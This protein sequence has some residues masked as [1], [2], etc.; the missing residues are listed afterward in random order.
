MPSICQAL[1]WK[2]HTLSF[3]LTKTRWFRFTQDNQKRW[4]QDSYL[5]WILLNLP[6]PAQP[7]LYQSLCSK[8]SVL[9]PQSLETASLPVSVFLS[10]LFSFSLTLFP[11]LFPPAP[12]LSGLVNISAWSLFPH[13]GEKC[14]MELKPLEHEFNTGTSSSAAS[15]PLLCSNGIDEGSQPSHCL[16]IPQNPTC[17]VQTAGGKS[18]CPKM[19]RPTG[20]KKLFQNSYCGGKSPQAECSVDRWEPVRATLSTRCLRLDGLGGYIHG[21]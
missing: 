14:V 16:L 7:H 13:S 1:I 3:T 2:L 5:E 20:R 11:A 9:M 19:G 15:G 6:W 10:F 8:T 12:S 17:F 21:G 18:W 4:S